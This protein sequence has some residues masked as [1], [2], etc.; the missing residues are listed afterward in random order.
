MQKALSSYEKYNNKADKGKVTLAD[1]KA[2]LKFCLHIIPEE[3]KPISHYKTKA[4][5]VAKME[6][7][8][9]ESHLILLVQQRAQTEKNLDENTPP[10]AQEEGT[11]GTA[12]IETNSE[13]VE[14]ETM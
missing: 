1:Y 11:L 3:T 14:E 13:Q 9:W 6:E 10:Q 12:T 8:N 4:E 7:I 2:I 5:I